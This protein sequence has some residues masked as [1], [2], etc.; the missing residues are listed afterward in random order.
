MNILITLALAVLACYFGW[1]AG[2]RKER[3]QIELEQASQIER[4]AIRAER[5]GA[6]RMKTIQIRR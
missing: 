4:A 2:R 5:N 6:V 1:L 3:G